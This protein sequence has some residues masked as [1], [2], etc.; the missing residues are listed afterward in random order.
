MRALL[1]HN[2]ST[3]GKKSILVQKYVIDWGGEKNQKGKMKLKLE[4][5]KKRKAESGCV[6]EQN[7][8]VFGIVVMKKRKYIP[9]LERVKIVCQNDFNQ[10]EFS[11][12]KLRMREKGVAKTKQVRREEEKESNN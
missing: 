8:A 7:I 5:D 10:C 4:R 2:L 12:D 11:C 9:Q 1:F 3:I 6:N